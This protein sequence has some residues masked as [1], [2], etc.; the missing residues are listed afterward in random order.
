MF[1]V[2]EEIRGYLETAL[3]TRIKTYYTGE[4]ALVPR[5]Y[6]P[7]LMIFGERTQ[8]IAKSTA[9]DQAQYDIG[10]RV[11]TDINTYYKESGTGTT[12]AHT[13]DLMKIM[14]E[15]NDNGTYKA[16]TVVGALRAHVRGTNY[17]FN[18]DISVEYKIIQQGEYF[19]CRAD[20]KIKAT[21]D[22][23]LRPNL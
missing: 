23:Y 13:E 11:E 20:L 1:L 15:R 2:L 7:A 4:V 16:N 19:V 22:L 6:L 3:T 8:I 10:I 21:T 5:S 18:N 17:L 14:E 12:I 9:K